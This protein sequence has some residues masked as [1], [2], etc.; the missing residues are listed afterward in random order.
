M[1]ASSC[2]DREISVRTVIV[3]AC[4]RL[5]DGTL[6]SISNATVSMVSES[7][8]KA[9]RTLFLWCP[10]HQQ[11]LREHSIKSAVDLEKVGNRIVAIASINTSKR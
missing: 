5:S 8:A 9:S 1:A 2:L 4:S 3:T 10:S 11:K 7:P 6:K